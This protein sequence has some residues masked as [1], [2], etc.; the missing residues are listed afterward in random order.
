MT[1]FDVWMWIKLDDIRQ[2]LMLV[3]ILIGIFGG[4]ATGFAFGILISA[5]MS[6][7]PAKVG[8][9]FVIFAWL[10]GGIYSLLPSTKQAAIIYAAPIVAN[11]QFLTNDVPAIYTLGVE[12]I[13]EKLIDIK[14]GETK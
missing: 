4:I 5:N 13:K 3:F 2:A 8:L 6:L 10:C 12:A 1:E 11:S 14:N 7:K 9:A